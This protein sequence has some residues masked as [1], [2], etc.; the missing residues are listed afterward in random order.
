[1]DGSFPRL[2][3]KCWSIVPDWFKEALPS[4]SGYLE[5]NR[6]L[7]SAL[8]KVEKRTR[9]RAEWTSGKTTER[10]FDYVSKKKITKARTET[11]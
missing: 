6:S 1:V 10:F 11:E 3:K 8:R 5:L 9:L 7:L 2:V 4:S